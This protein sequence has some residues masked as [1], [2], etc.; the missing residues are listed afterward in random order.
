MNLGLGVDT[1]GTYTDAVVID[2]DRGDIL[3]KAKALT[4][5]PNLAVGILSAIDSLGGFDPTCI[6]LVS[7]STTLATN[8]MVEGR[9]GKVALF[10]IGY[11]PR[12]LENQ[13]V[14]ANGD[15]H[16]VCVIPGGHSVMGVEK[17]P[18]DISALD[19]AIEATRDEVEA[20]AVSGHGGVRN[21]EHEQYARERILE[22]TGYP[23]VCGHELTSELGS[24]KR[25]VTAA[26][27]AR[28]LPLI[29]ELIRAVQY[30]LKERSIHAPLMVVK[31]DGHMMSAK[32]AA[33]KP[34]E[35]ILSGPAASVV[36]G[37]F[38]S[39]CDDAIVIDMGGTTTDIA[40]VH[41]GRPLLNREGASVGGWRTCIRAADIRTSG[42]GGDSH[43]R[44]EDGQVVL[45][46]RRVIPLALV[47][48][49]Q[50]AFLE[51]LRRLHQQARFTQLLSPT[52]GLML[53][54]EV[55][56]LPPRY[57]RL[58]ESLKQGPQ[59]LIHLAQE[60]D[61]M[62]ASLIDVHRLEQAGS[63]LRIGL[64]PTD[65]LHAQGVYNEWNN[66]AARIGVETYAYQLEES[67]EAFIKRIR[68]EVDRR[69]CIES[70]SRLFSE[71]HDEDSIVG[72][73]TCELLI[74]QGLHN[75]H[76]GGALRVRLESTLPLIAIGAPVKAYF[77][78]VAEQLH[79]TLHIPEHAEVANA[80]GA[81]AGTIVESAEVTV[82]PVYTIAGISH[83]AVHSA[84][85]LTKVERLSEAV[86]QATRTA[87]R[88]A[89]AQARKAGAQQ[90]EIHIEQD[91]QEGSSSE[92]ANIFLGTCIRAV[93]VGKMA[94]EERES[95]GTPQ[96][97][98]LRY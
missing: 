61:F 78:Q 64:T 24:I 4:T 44:L 46:T 48:S 87:R 11:D 75:G 86:E 22:R 41:E 16:K 25:A 33:Q 82:Q 97:L 70:L 72:C 60:L 94:F 5:R 15:I 43:I 52:D 49:Q 76:P 13:G 29:G 56:D 93:A 54:R 74:D 81:I 35:T 51:Q 69:L 90:V 7:I 10:A 36:G 12:I 2:F 66:E 83:Y 73:R 92:G 68:A 47:A 88:L 26:F 18:L 45:G 59:L 95:N 38:L 21:P 3:A 17:E 37:H 6:R 1:G 14:H 50:P 84:E 23:V 58:V 63:V 80:V 91:D 19:A 85:E 32:M 30:S 67:A 79:T 28:L 53:L 42:L 27:N 98:D 65:V 20:Y 55:D 89:L 9:G 62:H 71:Q 77:P 34:I 57:Q 39:G 31:G 96:R 40:V 8:A